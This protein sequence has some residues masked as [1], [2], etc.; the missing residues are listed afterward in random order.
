MLDLYKSPALR[1]WHQWLCLPSYHYYVWFTVYLLCTGPSFGPVGGSSDSLLSLASSKPVGAIPTT[2]PASTSSYVPSRLDSAL[3]S[4][5]HPLLGT[6]PIPPITSSSSSSTSGSGSLNMFL[7][8]HQ[9][10][11]PSS[12]IKVHPRSPASAPSSQQSVGS[13]LASSEWPDLGV[14]ITSKSAPSQWLP[15]TSDSTDS[16]ATKGMYSLIVKVESFFL[17][18]GACARV[19]VVILCVCLCVCVSVCL[20]VCLCVCLLPH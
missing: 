10:G 20:C 19:T 14:S 6:S 18:L 13:K 16:S 5:Y 11:F 2:A 12:S 4:T 7:G 1:V 17:T 3:S 9:P 8:Q 15:T